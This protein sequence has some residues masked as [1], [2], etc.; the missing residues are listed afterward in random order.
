MQAAFAALPPDLRV[1]LGPGLVGRLLDAGPSGRGAADLRHRRPARARPPTPAL[2]ARRG[3]ARRRRRPAA[4]GGAGARRARRDRRPRLGRGADRRSSASALDAGLPIPDRH[5]HRP[6]RRARCSTAAPTREAE[7]RGLLAEALAQPRRA[8]GGD[9]RGRGPPRA[10][11]RRAPPPSPRSAS[12]LLAERRSGR[13]RRRR[14]CRDRARPPRPHR[15]P[16]P[17]DDPARRAIIAA[18]WSTL[19][20]PEPALATG[21]P[22]ARRGSAGRPAGR[23]PGA[24]SSR[25]A[26]RRRAPRSGRSTGAEAAT[27][28]ARSF[29]LA[30]AYDQA[31]ATLA[32]RGMAEAAP[33]RLAVGRLV[34]GPRRRGRRSRPGWRWP[35]T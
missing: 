4:R 21:R 11:C 18:R 7:L 23:G 13:R 30:G 33:L 24:S 29:A 1:L 22:G 6:A 25:A 3:A 2:A 35:P 31:L 17:A 32:D 19:G 5:R 12:R 26:P 15:A 27:L 8:A 16:S 10:T 34:A 9:P 14:L 20:L 28:R